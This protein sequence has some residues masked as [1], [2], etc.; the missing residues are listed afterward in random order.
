MLSVLNDI[1]EFAFSG[2][3]DECDGNVVCF[4]LIVLVASEVCSFGDM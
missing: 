4:C 3:W 2:V 1:M